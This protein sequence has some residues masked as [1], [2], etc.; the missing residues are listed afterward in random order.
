M[1]EKYLY[2]KSPKVSFGRWLYT[3]IPEGSDELSF[4]KEVLERC[5]VNSD[6]CSSVG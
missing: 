6:D 4:Q 3:E 5:G 1:I 2:E